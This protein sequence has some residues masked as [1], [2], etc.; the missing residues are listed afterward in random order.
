MKKQA[1][2]HRLRAAGSSARK[3]IVEL[4]PPVNYNRINSVTL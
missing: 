2:F 4:F 3:I 1:K